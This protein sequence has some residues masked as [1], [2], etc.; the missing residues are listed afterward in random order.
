MDRNVIKARMCRLLKLSEARVPDDAVLTDIVSDSFML[1]ET[2]I[3]LQDEF[4]LRLTQQDL[5]G[6]QTVGQLLQL[7][8]D[9]LERQA[10]PAA[11]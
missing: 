1:V 5:G 8:V 3:E 9:R 7:F 6:V 4:G 10:R 11:S 2:F